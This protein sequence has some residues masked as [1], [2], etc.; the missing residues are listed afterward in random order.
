MYLHVTERSENTSPQ[1][2]GCQ[3]SPQ[4]SIGEWA[5]TGCVWCE[6]HGRR[7]GRRGK[8]LPD[9]DRGRPR[10]L[11]R[12]QGAAE[13]ATRSEPQCPEKATPEGW[14]AGCL[15]LRVWTG[16]EQEEGSPWV[17]Q[18]FVPQRLGFLLTLAG[19]R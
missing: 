11:P 17:E 4:L 3:C 5:V 8:K 10:K 16:W 18:A 2:P 7:L 15:G 6:P 14:L 13:R 12:V 1:K 9:L 19:L